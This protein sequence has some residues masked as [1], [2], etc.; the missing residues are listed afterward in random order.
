ML[1]SIGDKALIHDSLGATTSI[2]RLTSGT[3]VSVIGIRVSSTR[4]NASSLLV[5][6]DVHSD[7][8]VQPDNVFEASLIPLSYAV[9]GLANLDW[10]KGG[11]FYIKVFDGKGELINRARAYPIEKLTASSTRLAFKAWI[12][13]DLPETATGT[14]RFEQAEAIGTSSA[15]FLEIP[16][17]FQQW[18]NQTTSL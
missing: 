18:Q 4:L 1:V 16:I 14:I 8:P 17:R 9:T 2:D 3:E 12:G 6:H 13:F 11:F 10:Y 7:W 15:G 5:S